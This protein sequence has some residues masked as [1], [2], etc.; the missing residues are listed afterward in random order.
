MHLSVRNLM[1]FPAFT[2]LLLSLTASN[3]TLAQEPTNTAAETDITQELTIL[4]NQEIGP[5]EPEIETQQIPLSHKFAMSLTNSL[6]H[7]G[8]HLAR[9]VK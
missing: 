3:M 5:A 8:K 6:C 2:T 1:K 4:D 7:F 9:D